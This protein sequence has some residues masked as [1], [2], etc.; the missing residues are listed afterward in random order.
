[1]S[2][3]EFAE[4]AA[5]ARLEPFGPARADLRMANIMALLAEINRDRK[6]RGKP[7]SPA[8]FM[9]EFDPD[10]QKKDDPSPADVYA[11][12]RAWAAAMGAQKGK[13]ESGGT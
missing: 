10:A 1:M 4:W 13:A 2:S 9:F 8:E 6:K 3:A 5:F 12:V 7:F 11:K